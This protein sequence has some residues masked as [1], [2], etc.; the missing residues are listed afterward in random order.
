MFKK[1]NKNLARSSLNIPPHLAG[2]SVDQVAENPR[3]DKEPS[4]LNMICIS[5]PV[6]VTSGGIWFPH[7]RCIAQDRNLVRLI[8]E[9]T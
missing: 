4:V 5:F 1:V 9:S 6:V 8:P 3:W 2:S 7:V